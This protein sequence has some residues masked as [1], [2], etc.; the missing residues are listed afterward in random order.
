MYR[1]IQELINNALKHADAELF[2]VQLIR[3]EKK[4]A[5]FI[6]DDGKGFNAAHLGDGHGLKNMKNRLALINGSIDIDS[7]AGK[8]T[9]VSLSIPLS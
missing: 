7:A 1:V 3:S 4:L 5:G 2:S 8:G 9:S 6:S